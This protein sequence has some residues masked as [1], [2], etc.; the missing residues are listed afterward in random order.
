MGGKSNLLDPEK[1]LPLCQESFHFRTESENSLSV[2]RNELDKVNMLTVQGLKYGADN[3]YIKQSVNKIS[4]DIVQ[5]KQI[6]EKSGSYTLTKLSDVAM[7]SDRGE[8]ES[9]TKTLLADRN[10]KK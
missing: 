9:Q 5:L 3:E 7:L 10:L 2:I 6:L 8:Q 1:L 4:E